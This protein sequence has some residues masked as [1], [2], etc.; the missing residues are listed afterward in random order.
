MEEFIRVA[1]LCDVILT[2]EDFVWEEGMGGW[3]IDGMV[4]EEW[5]EAMTDE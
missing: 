3:T 1:A 2:P 4:P 5:L